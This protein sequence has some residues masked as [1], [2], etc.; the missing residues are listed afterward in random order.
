M[1][2]FWNYLFML[3]NLKIV[4]ESLEKIPK[5]IFFFLSHPLTQVFH[6]QL[7]LDIWGTSYTH[8]SR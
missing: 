4:E 7:Q 2:A 6:Q 8:I 3:E 1:N 5:T